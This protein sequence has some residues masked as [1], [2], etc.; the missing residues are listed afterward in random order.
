MAT[1][2]SAIQRL[3]DPIAQVSAHYVIDKLGNIFQLVPDELKAWHAGIS[4]WRGRDSINNYSIGIELDNNSAEPFPQ[5]QIDSLIELSK[6]L[7]S[8]HQIEQR[9]IIGHSDIAPDRKDDPSHYFNWKVLANNG[10]GIF[11]EVNVN[12]NFDLY[13]LG[14]TG[15]SILSLQDKLNAYGYKIQLT[16][17]FDEQTRLVVNAFKR[18]YCPESFF[19]N[20]QDI[21]DIESE[22][23]LN[24]IL[25]IVHDGDSFW[26]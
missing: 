11:P 19:N 26:L 23:K 4:H 22:L 15:E 20:T 24:K 8:K 16:G 9:N 10:I 12:D 13:T 1:A 5:A 18:H 14:D 25:D 2:S 3:C 6:E 7:L 17:E 21:W